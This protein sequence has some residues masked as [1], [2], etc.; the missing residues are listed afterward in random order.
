MEWFYI[1]LFVQA[2]TISN[3]IGGWSFAL[4][5]VG[6]IA[7][8]ILFMEDN[9]ENRGKYIGWCKL[10]MVVGFIGMVLCTLVPSQ[11]NLAIIIGSTVTYK[12]ITSDTGTRISNKAIELLEE[13]I[14]E[15]LTTA[16]KELVE[17]VK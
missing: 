17:K 15:A 7:F 14:D 9:L 12:A 8:F 16:P 3:F 2:E 13:Q 4:F 1:Y 11:K 10:F 6:L 5:L